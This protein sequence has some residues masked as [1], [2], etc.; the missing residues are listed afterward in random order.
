MKAA[1][2]VISGAIALA[3]IV[4]MATG[5]MMANGASKVQ[6]SD[7]SADQRVEHFA[8]VQN[9]DV[10]LGSAD[11]KITA[12]K[13]AED[14][15][16]AVVNPRDNLVI[17]ND[18]DTLVIKEKAEVSIFNFD[19][20]QKAMQTYI[21]IPEGTDFQN[22]KVAL[23]S[24]NVT[25]MSSFAANA[26]D[27]KIGSGNA[28]VQELKIA[29]DCDVK[30]GSGNASMERCEVDGK[31]NLKTGSGNFAVNGCSFGED[32]TARCGSGNMT[33]DGT[34]IAKDMTAHFGS[35]HLTGEGLE[36]GGKT[37]WEF[38]SG[39][40]ALNGF[41]PAK[42]VDIHVG[43]GDV[44]L[45]L[46]GTQDDYGIVTKDL[47]GDVTIGDKKMKDVEDLRSGKPTITV[48]GGSGDVSINFE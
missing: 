18:H 11:V 5:R 31:G 13:D 42:V 24:G 33:I 9:L 17:E 41:K 43:S 35:G 25:D 37:N 22:V 48:K 8:S 23:G 16:V 4:L 36:I 38:G 30:C 28:V 45:S 44:D 32:L 6:G 14:I 39:K 27:V 15:T 1:Y 20:N 34:K 21:T 19:F 10:D 12:A 26:V 7:G 29:K 40:V 3:G 47:S 46:I 2:W